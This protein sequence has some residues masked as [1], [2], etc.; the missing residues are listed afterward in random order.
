MTIDI[1][2]TINSN[3]A[4]LRSQAEVC[5]N[6]CLTLKSNEIVLDFGNLEAMTSAWINFLIIGLA[7]CDILNK[8]RIA[9]VKEAVWQ[10]KIDEAYKMATNQVYRQHVEEIWHSFIENLEN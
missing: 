2:T 9:H 6:H 7:D 3:R 1:A 8:V 4:L 10:L 5:L